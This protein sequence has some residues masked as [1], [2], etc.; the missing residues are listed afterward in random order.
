MRRITAIQLGA[1]LT[2]LSLTTGPARAN[3][4]FFSPVS[5]AAFISTNNSSAITYV[6]LSYASGVQNTS[7][8]F[9]TVD[10][11]LGFAGGGTNNFYLYFI[12]NTGYEPTCT[13]NLAGVGSSAG[14]NYSYSANGADTF[15]SNGSTYYDLAIFNPPSSGSFFYSVECTLAP[16]IAA[17]ILGVYPDH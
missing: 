3:T 14:T 4:A 9:L 17:T 12:A 8:Q 15:H 7:S 10:A 11:S 6:N 5:G 1:A 13:L 16:F 2:C